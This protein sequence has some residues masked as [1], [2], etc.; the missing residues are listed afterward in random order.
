MILDFYPQHILKLSNYPF[1][2]RSAST[3]FV[4]DHFDDVGHKHLENEHLVVHINEVSYDL[5]E[6]LQFKKKELK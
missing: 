3:K 1:A 4:F 6:K 2:H 5:K